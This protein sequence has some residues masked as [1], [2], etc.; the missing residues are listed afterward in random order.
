MCMAA[1][2]WAKVDRIVYSI[3]ALENNDFIYNSDELSI[4]EFADK[5]PREIS[6]ECI[7]LK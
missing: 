5:F 2:A 6:V 7:R 4:E 3:P 1:A